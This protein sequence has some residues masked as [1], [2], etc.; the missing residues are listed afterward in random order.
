VSNT[1][2]KM[3]TGPAR[4][5]HGRAG[6]SRQTAMKRR[7][8]PTCRACPR[9]PAAHWS[10]G[11]S[12]GISP[13]LAAGVADN[14]GRPAPYRKAQTPGHGTAASLDSPRTPPV[15]LFVRVAVCA[16]RPGTNRSAWPRHAALRRSRPAAR[17]A[18]STPRST[19]RNAKPAAAR[20]AATPHERICQDID[21][22][23]GK[24][25]SSRR[26]TGFAPSRKA[27]TRGGPPKSLGGRTRR[28]GRIAQGR[29]CFSKRLPA[30][31]PS[32]EESAF[33]R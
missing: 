13:H 6:S 27:A 2:A 31:G 16:W 9:W 23:D 22:G 17:S 18:S 8:V 5:R 30:R 14:P 11:R 33:G 3:K 4:D 12:D 10:A 24:P 29:T 32:V 25:K 1:S 15:L 26:R 28:A 7:H 19:T 20:T 21:V